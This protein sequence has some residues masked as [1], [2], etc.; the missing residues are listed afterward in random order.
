M[1]CCSLTHP[2]P[3]S[4]RISQWGEGRRGKVGAVYLTWR[5]LLPLFLGVNY[6][7]LWARWGRGKWMIYLTNQGLLLLIIHFT[8]DFV[9]AAMLYIDQH[10]KVPSNG[11][12][13]FVEKS[14][15]F[16]AN[17]ASSIAIMISLFFWIFLFQY[18]EKNSYGDTFVHGVNSISVLSDLLVSGRPMVWQHC[19]HPILA[20]CAYLAF[21][22]VY[23]A[24][25]GVD[26]YGHPW[27]YP[28]VDWGEKPITGAVTAIGFAAGLLVTHILLCLLTRLRVAAARWT[29]SWGQVE[30]AAPLALH[31]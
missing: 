7:I 3:T 11:K 24:L 31:C 13:S 28:M 20:G 16:L 18:E 23:W 25:G 2:F 14:G 5:L 22:V 30:E 8:W 19:F 9:L 15:W 4:L 1:S 6:F 27:I 17:S 12:M 26:P 10:H 21:S 29:I